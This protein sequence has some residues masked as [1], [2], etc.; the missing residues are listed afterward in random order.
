MIEPAMASSTKYI[1]EEKLLLFISKMDG[2]YAAE[3]AQAL[4]AFIVK[5]SRWAVDG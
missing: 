2:E 3:E 5:L 4:V 1:S